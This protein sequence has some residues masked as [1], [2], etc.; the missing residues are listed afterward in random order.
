MIELTK[1]ETGG[2]SKETEIWVNP[3]HIATLQPYVCGGSVRGT[4]VLVGGPFVV[5][6]II[7]TILQKIKADKCPTE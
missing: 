7:Y 3:A 6:E 2:S 4:K 5:K 1:I